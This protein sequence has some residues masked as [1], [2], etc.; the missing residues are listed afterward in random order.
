MQKENPCLT[1]GACCAH[2]RVSFY[3]TE[4]DPEEG[5]NVPPEL[6]ENLPPFRCNMIGTNQKNPRCIALTGKIGESVSCSI[7]EN[8][9][10]PCREFGIHWEKGFLHASNE[11]LAR[12]N[13]A[14]IAHHLP[15]IIMPHTY[16]PRVRVYTP[17]KTF[18]SPTHI[19]SSVLKPKKNPRGR[20]SA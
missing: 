4:A 3:W 15:P 5:G 12:C 2:F 10:S 14:R 17:E 11:E 8:R 9:P 1:C 7:Y 19:H 13:K 16:H 18:S 6:T 20:P